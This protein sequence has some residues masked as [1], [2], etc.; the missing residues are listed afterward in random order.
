RSLLKRLGKWRR[1]LDLGRLGVRSEHQNCAGSARTIARPFPL[2]ESKA[3]KT[4]TVR[5]AGSE[6]KIV[7]VVVSPAEVSEPDSEAVTVAVDAGL[8]VHAARRA[9]GEKPLDA[10]RSAV[11]AA[12]AY[13]ASHEVRSL[14]ALLFTA[15]RAGW[16]APT[17]S[18]SHASDLGERP[19]RI[20]VAPAQMRTETVLPRTAEPESSA[21]AWEA[22]SEGERAEF[23]AQ[24][25]AEVLTGG[26]EPEKS[27]A[28]RRGVESLPV[29]MRAKRLARERAEALGASDA[30]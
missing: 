10:V 16:L 23:L 17:P 11:R 13:A 7:D 20:I 4:T 24:A 8:T 22:L 25:F 26:T 9:V 15:I 28:R 5:R 18:S 12:R 6:S 1:E 2:E 14:P 27:L 19:Q 29:L 30:G 3:Q 21:A